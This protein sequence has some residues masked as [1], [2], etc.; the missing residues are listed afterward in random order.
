MTIVAG[1]PSRRFVVLAADSQVT[2]FNDKAYQAK[3]VPIEWPSVRCLVGGAGGKEFVDSAVQK[4]RELPKPV[5]T[6][7]R[8]RNTLT[9]IVSDIRQHELVNVSDHL[10]EDLAPSLLVA[11]WQ[12]GGALE[13]IKTEHVALR[14]QKPETVGSGGDL[15]RYLVATYYTALLPR[16]HVLRFAAYLLHEV[17]QYNPYCGGEGRIFWLDDKGRYGELSQEVI[18]QH[19]LSTTTVID[20]GARWLLHG[21]DPVD[22]DFNPAGIDRAIDNVTQVLKERF[23]LVYPNLPWPPLRPPR[24]GSAP[25]GPATAGPSPSTPDASG[26]PPSPGSDESPDSAS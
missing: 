12:K 14:Q 5:T 10:R 11:A 13:L 8:L 20:A 23:R 18:A 2:Y 19:E 17:K 1:F 4:L 7:R 24:P 9:A 3:I 15:A 25:S 6:L 26:P 16:D 21:V 22:W